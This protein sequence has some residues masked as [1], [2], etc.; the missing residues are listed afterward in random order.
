[1]E[2]GLRLAK[3]DHYLFSLSEVQDKSTLFE[4]VELKTLNPDKHVKPG[5]YIYLRNVQHKRWV[6]FMRGPGGYRSILKPHDERTEHAV[7]KIH[8]ASRNEIWEINYLLSSFRMISKFL[9]M[10][11][12]SAYP[13]PTNLQSKKTYA[14]KIGRV[15]KCIANLDDFVNNRAYCTSIDQQYGLC[16]Q[17]R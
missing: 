2:K 1:M 14:T 6:D 12:S 9:V 17:E 13:G 3:N 10:I 7:F 11:Q 16:N 4:F 5:S 15:C 8:K